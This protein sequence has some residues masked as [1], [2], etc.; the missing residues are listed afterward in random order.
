MPDSLRTG[1]G[2]FLKRSHLSGQLYDV[3]LFSVGSPCFGVGTTGTLTELSFLGRA[4]VNELLEDPI[5]GRD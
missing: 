2:A 5:S 1:L 4:V 3:F